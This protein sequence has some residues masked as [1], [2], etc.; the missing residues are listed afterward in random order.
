MGKVFVPYGDSASDTA[1]LL[2]DAAESNDDFTQDDVGT[3][4]GGFVVDEELA[5][6][7]GVKYDGEAASSDEHARN[8]DVAA[9]EQKAAPPKKAARGRDQGD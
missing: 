3:T 5:K 2:L 6:K 4:D 8:E 9:S 7:A 1:V